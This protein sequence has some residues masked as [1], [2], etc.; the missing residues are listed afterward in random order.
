M[1]LSLSIINIG[2]K[3][4]FQVKEISSRNKANISINFTVG[5]LDN[6]SL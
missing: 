3:L 1:D 6:M 5:R 2:M 4:N